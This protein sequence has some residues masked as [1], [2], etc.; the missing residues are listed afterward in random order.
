MR[1][2]ALLFLTLAAAFHAP[3]RGRHPM[4]ST[5]QIRPRDGAST[6]NFGRQFRRDDA[7]A[8]PREHQQRLDRFDVGNGAQVGVGL[9]HG[10]HLGFKFKLPF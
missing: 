9:V 1:Y 3:P 5:F 8:A 7:A 6:V 2:Y 4:P 10:R